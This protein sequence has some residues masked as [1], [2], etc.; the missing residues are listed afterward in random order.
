MEWLV[1]NGPGGDVASGEGTFRQ[2]SGERGP[3]AATSVHATFS[4]E[5]VAELQV[6]LD[7]LSDELTALCASGQLGVWT[8]A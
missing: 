2:R 6:K 1:A 3:A 5:V 8:A 4:A 7:A